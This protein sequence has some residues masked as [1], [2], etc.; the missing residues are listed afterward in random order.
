M[1]GDVLWWVILIGV[2]DTVLAAA[3]T[4]HA[5][6]KKRDTR[7]IIS[8]VGLAWL[9]PIFGSLSYF[10][11]G[12]N[13][14]SR[15]HAVRELARF[16]QT[17]RIAEMVQTLPQDTWDQFRN[18]EGLVTLV[19]N[20]ARCPLTEGNLVT[21]L[22]NGDE[23]YPA[24]LQA[25]HSAQ[26]SISLQSYIFDNDEAGNQ[27][28]EA[29][30]QAIQRGV[31]VRVLIDDVGSQYSRPSMIRELRNAGIPV[32]TFLPTRLPRLPKYANLRNH[33]KIMVVDG[34]TGF[35]GGTNIRRDHVL[36]EPTRFPVAC[37]HFQ[38]EGPVV[39]HLQNVFAFD[40]EYTTGEKLAGERWFCRQ[41]QPG[42]ILARGIAHGPDEDFEKLTHVIA[43]ALAIARRRVRIMTPYFLP[44]AAMIQA[45]NLAALRGVT[46][47]IF[48]PEINNIRM[49]HWAMMAQLWQNIEKGCRIYLVAPPFDHSKLMVV[50]DIW[51]LIGSTNWD[52]RSLRLNFE[53][54]LECYGESLAAVINELLDEKSFGSRSI[55]LEE[56]H[57]RP[58]LIKLRDGVSRLFSPYL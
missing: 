44:D 11:F 1:D 31:E 32:A 17:D 23:A 15:R 22:R 26:K 42:R 12:I 19:G 55:T 18:L 54:N 13:R 46:V 56:L 16:T 34:T 38:I 47:E 30:V 5:V 35:T 7:S 53:F 37:T 58:V 20:I 41:K 51:T 9:A 21:T 10:W 14:I 24:M 48:V 28:L 29:L 39:E 45:L 33:R 25:I 49:V 6:L 40:W 8:W 27:F 4:V 43:G 52:A 57:Q 50:D 3:V 2:L 36:S